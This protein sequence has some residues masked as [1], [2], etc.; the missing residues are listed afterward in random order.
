MAGSAFK[1][2]KNDQIGTA[3]A[4][5]DR[6][7]LSI[8]FVDTGELALLQKVS[9][10][11]QI[12][13][14][15]TGTGKSAL[16]LKLAETKGDQVIQI[17]PESLALTYVSNSTI[18]NFFA[19]IGVN[20]DPFFKLL[21]RHVLTVEILDRHFQH[22]PE[23]KQRNIL[24]W[25]TGLFTGNSRH[26]K[27]MQ[28]AIQYLKEWG[29]SFWQETE[30]RVKEITSKL[31][32]EL[33]GEFKAQLGI[34]GI[35]S[36][37]TAKAL[38]KLTEEQRVE[39]VSRGQ[40]IVSKAQVQDLSTVLDLLDAVL[41][42]RQ[43]PYYIIIDKLDENWV[44]ERIRYKLI[45]ALILTAKDFFH[46]NNAKI[47]I[48]LRRDLIERVFRLTRDSGFQEEKYQS[49]Y[50]PLFWTKEDLI[51]VLD[52]RVDALV[53]RRYT[54]QKVSYKDLLPKQY[55]KMV[56]T[57]YLLERVERPRDVIAFFNACIAAGTNISTLTRKEF[58]AAEG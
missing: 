47:I 34:K 14:G 10:H 23:Q 11:R 58:T 33:S 38:Q 24:D 25:L 30:F 35:S 32:G 17:C 56:I 7:F 3:G 6:E 57:D 43:K 8:C 28:E 1:F 20:L 4:E 54:K 49:L 45:M 36:I 21:W 12:V 44:E 2:R 31:E 15:R 5:E 39:L 29:E 48:A 55:N 18:L 13:L 9:D 41:E 46:V 22:Y 52:L 53:K 16:L 42:D 51:K 26:D 19:K 50:M 27:K 40:G 37:A